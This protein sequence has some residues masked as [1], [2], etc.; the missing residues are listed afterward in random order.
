MGVVFKATHRFLPDVWAVKVMRPELCEDEE[1]RQRFLSEVMVLSRLRHENIIEIQAPFEE[2]GHLYLPMEYLT[3]NSLEQML[4]ADGSRWPHLRAIDVIAQ[5]A[6]GLGHAHRQVPPVLHRDIKPSNIQV[7]EDGRVKI[8]DFGL[9]RTIG[10][11]SIT[12]TGKAVGTPAYMAPESLSGRKATPQ[13]DVFSLG[14][15]LYRLLCGR[16]PYD[17]PEEDSSI[18][19]VFAAVFRGIDKGIPDVRE[20]ALD[21]PPRLARLTMRALSVVPESRPLDGAEFASLLI[22]S[23][24]GVT[25]DESITTTPPSI[26]TKPGSDAT[27]RPR[28]ISQGKDATRLGIDIENLDVRTSR[29][30]PVQREHMD[31][32]HSLL[33]LPG[34]LDLLS[35]S[36]RGR[37][38]SIEKATHED[39]IDRKPI[40]DLADTVFD[41]NRFRP[42]KKARV[43]V[44][45]VVAAVLSVASIW[46]YFALKPVIATPEQCKEACDRKLGLVAA[47]Q[48]GN[49]SVDPVDKVN[50]A[51]DKEVKNQQ[52]IL[53]NAIAAIQTE[54]DEA[55]EALVDKKEIEAAAAICKVHKA[56]KAEEMAPIFEELR[57]NREKAVNAAM[58]L[59]DEKAAHRDAELAVCTD[60]CIISRT[61]ESTALCRIAATSLDE[62]NACI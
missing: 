4:K 42:G 25:A 20:F 39:R 38:K 46:M 60:E 44:L 55:F 54:C 22:E 17:M 6:R 36:D 14:I 28:V 7:M 12:A 62:F 35:S 33:N 61:K 43:A 8:L 24:G 32:D 13:S 15:V 11:K 41:E 26:E 18:H 57:V 29:P 47:E 19:A 53:G 56:A 9:A 16:L 52:M 48:N 45:I 31:A 3:G 5:A 50:E 34:R 49:G 59:R 51:F 30:V 23:C 21:I 2:D 40:A 10:E 37:G 27:G 1:S 58:K